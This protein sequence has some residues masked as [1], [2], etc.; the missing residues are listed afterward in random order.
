MV[1]D[2]ADDVAT[3]GVHEELTVG[4]INTC[5]RADPNG[6]S[7]SDKIRDWCSLHGFLWE[8]FDGKDAHGKKAQFSRFTRDRRI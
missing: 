8:T 4:L 2:I 1:D 6:A 3:N 7:Y 5:F